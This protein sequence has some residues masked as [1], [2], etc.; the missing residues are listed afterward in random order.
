MITKRILGLGFS[1]I[2][3]LI[4]IGLFAIDLLRASD[5]QGIGPTQRMGLIVGAIIF[6]VGL[7]L[8]PLGNR[9]A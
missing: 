4:I 5:Y 9:P 7:T 2:G 8:I 1:A 6:T 3:L